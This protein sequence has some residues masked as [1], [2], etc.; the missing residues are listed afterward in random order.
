MFFIFETETSIQVLVLIDFHEQ[1]HAHGCYFPQEK[2]RHL[3][4]IL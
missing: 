2:L 1:F 4:S 3:I